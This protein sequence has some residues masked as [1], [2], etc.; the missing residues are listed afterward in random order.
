MNQ[1]LQARERIRNK[2]MKKYEF[3]LQ[4]GKIGYNHRRKK[5]MARQLSVDRLLTPTYLK[6]P[7]SV[8]LDI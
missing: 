1:L 4:M 5:G 3:S 8:G 6:H 2:K 7:S